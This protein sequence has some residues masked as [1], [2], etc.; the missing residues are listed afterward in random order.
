MLSSVNKCSYI[1]QRA[2]SSPLTAC[3]F[4]PALT[5]EW[6]CFGQGITCV[7]ALTCTCDPTLLFWKRV[8]S[9]QS[10]Q[11]RRHKRLSTFCVRKAVTDDGSSYFVMGDYTGVIFLFMLFLSPSQAHLKDWG[12]TRRGVICTFMLLLTASWQLIVRS[13]KCQ[14][15]LQSWQRSSALVRRPRVKKSTPT[16]VPPPLYRYRNS[17]RAPAGHARFLPLLAK[18]IHGPLHCLSPFAMIIIV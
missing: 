3:F 5:R 12:W 11:V 13:Q 6:G 2:D 14:L 1:S 15:G 9:V 8:H 7:A 16:P 17:E 4:C 10:L 18:C